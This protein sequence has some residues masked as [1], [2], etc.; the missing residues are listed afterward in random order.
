MLATLYITVDTIVATGQDVAPAGSKTISTIISRVPLAF[1]A[2]GLIALTGPAPAPLLA[3]AR[4]ATAPAA[5]V[6]AEEIKGQIEQMRLALKPGQTFAYQP[7][8]RAGN[9]D[10]AI[11]YWLKPGKPAVHPDQ[12]EYVV[13]LAGSGTLV[14]GGTMTDAATTN[15]TLIEGGRI[16][17]G[18]TRALRPG[19]VFLIAAG[20]PHWFGITGQRLVLLGT[21][22][23]QHRG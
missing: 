8:V 15:P 12:A 23:P 14:S 10:A 21:K 22:I 2:I 16:I 18:T 20:T 17:G 4:E 13:V 1:A 3:Q 11:E 6:P 7:I 9:A 5:Y 19:D